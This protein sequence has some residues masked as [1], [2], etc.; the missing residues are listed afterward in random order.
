MQHPTT[1]NRQA[2]Q[3]HPPDDNTGNV[4]LDANPD[5]DT[6]GEDPLEEQWDNIPS[7]DGIQP[8]EPSNHP[9]PTSTWRRNKGWKNIWAGLKIA[10][11][12]IKSYGQTGPGSKWLH[13]NHLIR[14]KHI[15]VLAVQETHMNEDQRREIEDLF[16][17]CLRIFASAD[18][19]NPMQRAG[20][21]L[22]LHKAVVD[23]DHI[24]Q[25]E[26]IPGRAIL[27]ILNWNR[28]VKL[29]ILAVYAPNPTTENANFWEKITT[30]FTNN[31]RLPW[32]QIML[33]DFNMVE[34]AID[35]LPMHEER[36]RSPET[37]RELKHTLWLCDGWR[38]TFPDTKSYAFH[39]TATGARSRIDWIY[40]M[41]RLLECSQKWEIN[42]TGIPNAD[43]WMAS[44]NLVNS[45]IPE[46][47]K[48]RWSISPKIYK[49]TAFK[50]TIRGWKNR[51]R[52]TW[53]VH[54]QSKNH[55]EQHTNNLC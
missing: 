45:A 24:V 37:L 17:K 1:P 3:P 48:G 10:S 12:N 15:G 23:T 49:D 14:E 8:D 28:E 20:I 44:I 6:G 5:T 13:I 21:A 18:S 54:T 35:R 7:S 51:N 22:V 19:T 50:K 11:L 9:P 55:G 41:N 31:W 52:R 42:P 40:I 46:A 30:S 33:G 32:P 53:Q 29:T 36:N 27:V 39:Q 16:N 38:S 34:D 2:T 47:G 25:H 26:I 4:P 43:H